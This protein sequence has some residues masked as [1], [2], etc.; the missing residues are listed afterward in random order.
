MQVGAL[1]CFKYI[2]VSSK[3]GNTN[4]ETT[5]QS[6]NTQLR[7]QRS[8]KTH[9]CVRLPQYCEK[10]IYIKEQET[11]KFVSEYILQS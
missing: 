3:F 9:G 10:T 1:T 4:H 8:A 11:Y 5:L 2:H 6:S 7:A